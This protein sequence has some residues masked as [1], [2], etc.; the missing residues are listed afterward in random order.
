MTNL[1]AWSLL[2]AALASTTIGCFPTRTSRASAA[3]D[4]LGVV[5]I[6]P[7]Q[8][9]AEEDEA[10]APPFDPE[11]MKANLAK[12]FPGLKT[13]DFL[14][15][16]IAANDRAGRC[17]TQVPPP[18]ETKIEVDYSVDGKKRSA[19]GIRALKK[20]GWWPIYRA[21]QGQGFEQRANFD[22]IDLR[23][24]TTVECHCAAHERVAKRG[25]R[26][27][28]LRFRWTKGKVP[29]ISAGVTEE[30]KL[31]G[32]SPSITYGHLL[33]YDFETKGPFA[34]DNPGTCGAH[35]ILSILADPPIV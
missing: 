21:P 9:E 1:G 28:E 35:M 11:R 2:A 29:E 30:K 3:P 27:M 31:A 14:R 6:D 33:T 4:P 16:V 8:P 10:D 15:V 20:D 24:A 5:R 26:S 13:I 23:V 22:S 12:R 19:S 34:E 18:W 32:L 7:P 17:W 25:S